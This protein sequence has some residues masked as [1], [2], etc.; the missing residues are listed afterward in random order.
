[1]LRDRLAAAVVYSH[2]LA[3]NE[4]AF[5]LSLLNQTCPETLEIVGASRAFRRLGCSQRTGQRRLRAFE[6]R[7]WV[8]REVER[9]RE[10]GAWR[11]RSR[12]WFEPSFLQ[13]FSTALCDKLSREVSFLARKVIKKAQARLVQTQSGQTTESDPSN[14]VPAAQ[15]SNSAAP[16]GSNAGEVEPLANAQR[17][18][19]SNAISTDSA[20]RA[21]RALPILPA[22]LAREGERFGLS[23]VMV[24]ALMKFARSAGTTVQLAIANSATRLE[25]LGLQGRAAMAYLVRVLSG[26]GTKSE[27]T[28]KERATH[29]AV[30]ARLNGKF[31]RL[32]DGRVGRFEVGQGGDA[33]LRLPEGYMPL[34]AKTDRATR[35]LEA[36]AERKISVVP[37]VTDRHIRATS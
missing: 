34:H 23:P 1:M 22:P 32:H 26:Q 31:V 17:Q 29:G 28:G 25:V 10:E 36:L 13:M 12:V 8:R 20:T 2:E 33:W 4:R 18:I 24:C 11:A 14:S 19:E 27:K 5:A 9:W 37:A 35:F 16:G 15:A 7:G 21:K 6:E 3:F 30:F